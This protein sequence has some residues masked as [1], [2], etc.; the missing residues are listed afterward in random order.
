MANDHD[1]D[2]G[3]DGV[4][5]F[6]EGTFRARA[7]WQSVSMGW[8]KDKTAER[9]SIRLRVT[10]EYPSVI[11]KSIT[12]YGGFATQG[13]IDFAI[14]ALR[15]MGWDGESPIGKPGTGA[16]AMLGSVD[17]EIVVVHRTF[18][19]KT[20]AEVQYVNALGGMGFKDALDDRAIASLNDRIKRHMSATAPRPQAPRQPP[21]V[22]R[23][24]QAARN[25]AQGT[26]PTGG[27]RPT[28]HR[29]A[30]NPNAGPTEPIRPPD[31]PTGDDD[32]PY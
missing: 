14:K 20:R 25:I 22:T 5:S 2:D 29:L 8:N 30:P 9:I 4:P 24:P 17:C 27:Q 28:H 7:D 26:T 15:A 21:P 3:A 23:P 18:N 16:L 32:I 11:G 12:W 1:D 10:D 31:Y 6:P 13:N 19:D